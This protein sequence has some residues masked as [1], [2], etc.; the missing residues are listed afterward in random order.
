M[1]QEWSPEELLASWTLVDG[2]WDLVANKSGSTRLGFALMLKFFESEGRFPDLLEEV[3]QSAV[4]YV[5]GLVKVPAADFAKYD[6]TSRSAKNHRK[7]IREAL[8]F[9]PATRADEEKLIEWLA[10]EVCPVELVEDRLREALLVECRERSIEPPGRIDRIVTAAQ[11]RAEKAFCARTIE[12]LGGGVARLLALVAEDNEDGAALLAALKRD[13]GAVGLDSL[14]AEIIKLND[15]RKLGL[16]DGLFADC[17]EKLLAAWRARAIKMYP[18]DF[19]D[20]AEDVRITLLAALCSSRQTEITDALVDLLVA[21]VQKIN[22]RAE[23]RVERQLTAE[24]KKV[25][26]KEG[27]LFR[28]ADA[29]IGKPDEIVRTALYPR[30]SARRRCATWSPRRRRMRRS[31]R[32]R[33]APRCARRTARTTD[34]CCR[35]C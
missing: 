12:R 26:G 15:V 3:P 17:S 31:S 1:R 33:S 14:L 35:R 18:S 10:D 4:E 20:T 21:L 22:A 5:A 27:I 25:R 34:R 6:L 23:R 11:T 19:R 7:Q 30:S 16:P 13:P 29:A 28:L 8:K 2:D 32:P 9:R 24:L